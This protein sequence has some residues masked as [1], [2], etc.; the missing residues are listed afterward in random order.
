MEKNKNKKGKDIV[1]EDGHP[2]SL[3]N[4]D[5]SLK[6]I[7]DDNGNLTEIGQM[8]MMNREILSKGTYY[9]EKADKARKRNRKLITWAIL[10]GVIVLFFLFFH[11][12][13]SYEGFAI[14]PKS[15]PTFSHTFIDGREVDD[16]L[17]RYNNANIFEQA[18]MQNE[19]FMK[20]L[21]DRG[22]ISIGEKEEKKPQADPYRRENSQSLPTI[23]LGKL[24]FDG[25]E[26]YYTTSVTKA[27]ANKLGNYLVDTGA[28]DGQEISI[29]LNKRGKTY[30]FR[31]VVQKGVEQDTEYIDIFKNFTIELSQNVFDGANVDIHLCDEYFKTIRVVPMQGY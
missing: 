15:H 11:I 28:I 13:I 29:Q 7:Y 17:R 2:A 6:N 26:I 12:Y 21:I 5:G 3:R 8:V 10:A 4:A 20:L 9:E 1:V 25:T 24:V 31:A 27:E 19:P 18:L 14:K 16:L 23:N 22:F 30:E